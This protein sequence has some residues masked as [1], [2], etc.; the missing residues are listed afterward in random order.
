M[1]E[2]VPEQEWCRSE[3]ELPH[4]SAQPAGAMLKGASAGFTLPELLVVVVIIGVLAAIAVPL[5]LDQ[6]SKA[7][8][9]VVE[10][11]AINL[12]KLV[13]A[14]WIEGDVGSVTASADGYAID[15]VD[16]LSRS[17]GVEFVTYVGGT[18]ESWCVQLR[19]PNGKDNA[20]PGVR[21]DSNDGYVSG[22]A[23]ATP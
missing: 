10:S 17:P 11:D 15:G 6:Q 20:S 3:R 19:H 2:A 23:C 7:N 9:S 5:Y 13:S 14:A 21:F 18:A 1:R 16:V 4:Q 12:G 22:A 8:D